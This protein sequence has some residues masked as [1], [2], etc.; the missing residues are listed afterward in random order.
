M[1]NKVD[2]KHENDNCATLLIDLP[3]GQEVNIKGQNFIL[4]QVIPFG[5]EFPS[6]DL[7]P[8]NLVFKYGQIIGINKRKIQ[9]GE[10]INVYDLKVII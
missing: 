8:E 10:W 2:K 1:L 6:S 5:H 3:Q 9:Q 4:K 7:P